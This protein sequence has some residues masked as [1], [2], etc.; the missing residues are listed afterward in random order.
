M[1][2]PTT[3]WTVTRNVRLGPDSPGVN[4]HDGQG[5]MVAGKSRA[6]SALEPKGR[7]SAPPLEPRPS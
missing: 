5:F 6:K 3:T 4:F 7:P 1:L 2:S